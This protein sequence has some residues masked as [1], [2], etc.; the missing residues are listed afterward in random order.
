MLKILGDINFSDGF[1][2]MGFGV[3]SAIKKGFDPFVKLYRKKTD[4]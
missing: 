2:D 1:F 3:G 4:F